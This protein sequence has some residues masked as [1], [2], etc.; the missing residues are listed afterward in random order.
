VDRA[1][2]VAGGTN[3][4]VLMPNDLRFGLRSSRAAW[5]NPTTIPNNS[6][7]VAARWSL[8][9]STTVWAGGL[10]R[11]ASSH[12]YQINGG[13]E[14]RRFCSG[15]KC[16]AL[17]AWTTWPPLQATNGELLLYVQRVRGALEPDGKIPMYN[18]TGRA[19]AWSARG[20]N[21]LVVE[22]V[23]CNRALRPS[24]CQCYEQVA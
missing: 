17:S 9:Y 22:V 10:I 4:Y 18:S 24:K 20:R 14:K 7:I 8:A 3:D 16:G 21:G 2:S 23:L 15:F 19:S 12:C 13:G 1:L 6:Q 5:V 11:R